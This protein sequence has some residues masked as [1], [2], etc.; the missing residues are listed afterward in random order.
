MSIKCHKPS[1]GNSRELDLVTHD[2]RGEQG[3]YLVR[4]CLTLVLRDA[5]NCDRRDGAMA[6]MWPYL[7]LTIDAPL[8]PEA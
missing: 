1:F 2:E 7:N 3:I 5:R 6:A 8:P 4:D